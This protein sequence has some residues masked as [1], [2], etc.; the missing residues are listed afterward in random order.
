M[1]DT[2]IPAQAE[3]AAALSAVDL[4]AA[5]LASDDDTAIYPSHRNVPLRRYALYLVVN[6]GP[7]HPRSLFVAYT[8]HEP[9]IVLTAHPQHFST[10][11]HADGLTLDTPDAAVAWA[12]AYLET[13]RTNAE[14]F[15]VVST[16]DDIL[17][18]NDPDP[19][20][21]RPIVAFR[22]MY[23]TQIAPPRAI[24]GG[25]PFDVVAWAIREQSLERH[26]LHVTLDGNISDTIET[27]ASDL[28]LVYSD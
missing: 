14:I 23:A 7:D 5:A 1:S 16:F 19:D 6:Y 4:A 28:P 18:L 8:P 24:A 11:A 26:H 15:Y 10:L 25:P 20:T 13:T 2:P 21:A 22:A 3:L 12:R 27:V 9:A 17:T